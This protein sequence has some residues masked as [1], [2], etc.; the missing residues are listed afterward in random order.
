MIDDR[1]L[2]H[3]QL[4]L[5]TPRSDNSLIL[6]LLLWNARGSV[7]SYDEIRDEYPARDIHSTISEV[8]F[9]M[10]DLEWPIFIENVFA[11]G[12][13]LIVRQAGWSWD[14][15]ALFSNPDFNG[16]A[17]IIATCPGLPRRAAVL[18]QILWARANSTVTA[19]EVSHRYQ[20][21]TGRKA[22][23]NVLSEGFSI[24]RKFARE[25]YWPL[26]IMSASAIGYRLVTPSHDATRP[27]A[28][29]YAGREQTDV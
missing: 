20:T 2:H 23:R 9:L 19:S 11:S 29:V 1:D 15:H 22:T 24:I 16:A 21:V 7:V 26:S 12:Y 18:L 13:R 3:A 4:K 14:N 28:Q 27:P 6:F 5:I 17:K 8:R 10:T 25:N